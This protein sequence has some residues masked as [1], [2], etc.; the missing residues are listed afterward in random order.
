MSARGDRIAA[1]YNDREDNDRQADPILLTTLPGSLNARSFEG[2]IVVS[3]RLDLFP[4]PSGELNLLAGRNISAL[5]AG[6]IRQSDADITTLPTPATPTSVLNGVLWRDLLQGH[7]ALPVH[8]FDEQPAMIVARTGTIGTLGLE[9]LSLSLAKAVNVYAGVD[10]ANLS[11][12]VQHARVTDRSILQA[13]RDIMYNTS[14]RPD[15]RLSENNG[16]L[17]VAGP[18]AV[19]LIGGR[20][21][22]FG[23]SNGLESRGNLGNPALAPRGADI[24]LWTGYATPPALAA[25]AAR[26]LTGADSPYAG[27]LQSALNAAGVTEF[28]ALT[29]S[30]QREVVMQVLFAELEASGLESS[31]PGQSFARGERAIATLFPGDNY[32]GDLRSFLSRINTLDGGSI[33]ALVPGGQVNAGVASTGAIVKSPAQLGLVVH[34]DGDI[35][36]YTLGDFLVNTSRVFVLDGGDILIWSA[37]GD[38]NAGKGARSALSIPPPTTSFDAQGNVVIEI[39]AAIA[40]SGIQA[41]VRT[42]GRAPGDVFLFA[43]RGVVDAGDAGISSAGNLTIAATAVLGAD[44]ISVGGA[45]AG[46]PTTAVS[47]PVGLASASAAAG[48]ATSAATAGASERANPDEEPS[49]NDLGA[50]LASMVTVQFLGFGE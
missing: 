39:P 2:D 35:N 4:A 27:E 29:L 16:L 42:P 6:D 31:R 18:G 46:V 10:I 19:D 14:R 28:S 43:P 8:R 22:D 41:G 21:I 36:A 5:G 3:E 1:Q 32:P 44:N 7:A 45:S 47:V 13:A 15:G 34:G 24:N 25:F 9:T 33:N 12:T 11:L 30:L 40:G 37:E 17:A 38:I 23:A 26:Y 20:E 49:A 50:S 48:S